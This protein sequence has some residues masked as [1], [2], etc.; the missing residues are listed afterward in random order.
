MNNQRQF[1]TVTLANG[2]KRAINLDDVE[3]FAPT[4]LG[5]LLC[6]RG[7]NVLQT[8]EDFEALNTAYSYEMLLVTFAE[9]SPTSTNLRPGGD[10]PLGH[11][12][13]TFREVRT[14]SSDPAA[15]AGDEVPS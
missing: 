3:W 1:L 5:T 10:P 11:P 15:N 9:T 8:S 14:V 12:W 6:F 7:G 4:D 2:G 13:R